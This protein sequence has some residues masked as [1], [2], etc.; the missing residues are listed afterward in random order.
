[1]KTPKQ[2]GYKNSRR[3]K[4]RQERKR[5]ERKARDKARNREKVLRRNIVFRLYQTIVHHFPDL[6]DKIRTPDMGI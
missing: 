3:Y 1:M 5:Q 4:E 6:F 2:V